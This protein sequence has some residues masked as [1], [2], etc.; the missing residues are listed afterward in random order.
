MLALFYFNLYIYTT[1]AIRFALADLTVYIYIFYLFSNSD[2]L[3]S[4]L[5]GILFKSKTVVQQ[6]EVKRLDLRIANTRK[7][8]V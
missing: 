6:M 8:T 2:L 4:F 5:A 7:I 3:D 1:L